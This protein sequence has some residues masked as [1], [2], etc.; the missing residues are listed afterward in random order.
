VAI[1]TLVTRS[2]GPQL[3]FNVE[4]MEISHSLW[5]VSRESIVITLQNA[6]HVSPK[7]DLSYGR[8]FSLRSMHTRGF[9]IFALVSFFFFSLSP[10]LFLI[11]C[12]LPLS[13]K[14]QQNL[15]DNRHPT[16]S[17]YF[18]HIE[19]LIFSDSQKKISTKFHAERHFIRSPSFSISFSM[20]L[21]SRGQSSIRLLR[22]GITSLIVNS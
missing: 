3:N 1:K 16:S 18:S 2:Y 22:R 12:P 4:R 9:S 13:G 10:S 11:F 8:T 17:L 15:G 14:L 21:L 5:E 6:L 20:F 7:C 19:S